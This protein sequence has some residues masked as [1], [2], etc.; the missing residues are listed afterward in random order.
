MQTLLTRDSNNE[1]VQL[2]CLSNPQTISFN[3]SAGAAVLSAAFL[4]DV[5]R[6]QPTVDVFILDTV[7]GAVTAGTGHF[8]A[9]GACYDIPMTPGATKLSFLAVGAAGGTAF[10]SELG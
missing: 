6:V 1:T 8:L 10:L 5:I 7:A 4:R 3:G 2:M 9:G